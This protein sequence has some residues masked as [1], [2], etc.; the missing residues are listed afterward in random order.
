VARKTDILLIASLALSLATLR[1]ITPIPLMLP[2]GGLSQVPPVSATVDKLPS[3]DHG[4]ATVLTN[5]AS[6]RTEAFGQALLG[7]PRCDGSRNT[8]LRTYS[9]PASGLINPDL[10]Q[11]PIQEIDAAGHWLQKFAVTAIQPRLVGGNFFVGHTGEVYQVAW[12]PRKSPVW[13]IV[14]SSKGTEQR[15]INI[16]VEFQPYQ[17]AVYST[18]ELFLSGL[19]YPNERDREMHTPFAGIFAQDGTILRKLAF[20][21]DRKIQAA[22]EE[23]NPAFVSVNTPWQGNLAV[24]Y[25]DV[26]VGADGNVYL[27]RRTAPALIYAVSARGEVL[28]TLT[29]REGNGDWLPVSIVSAGNNLAVTFHRDSPD[30]TVVRMIDFKGKDL[31]T[32]QL[33]KDF[34]EVLGCYVAP[35]FYFLG[36]RDGSIYLYRGTP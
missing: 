21:E 2:W 29:I 11:S 22:A 36:S 8:F 5:P 4:S 1:L 23:A 12:T 17:I 16:S 13:V 6:I 27:L 3:G 30:S 9:A 32:Y 31:S 24:E 18:G 28:R 14:F 25:G 20:A 15:I 19:E 33:D 7:L 35:E 34:G 26:A 10:L